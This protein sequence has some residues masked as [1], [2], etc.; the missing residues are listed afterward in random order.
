VPVPPFAGRVGGVKP[1]LLRHC[2]KAVRWELELGVEADADFAEVL[3]LLAAL[4]PHA[5]KARAAVVAASAGISRRRRGG[6][7]CEE[8]IGVLWWLC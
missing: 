4:L 5:A 1:W 2:T 6:I 8:S 7:V 3:E